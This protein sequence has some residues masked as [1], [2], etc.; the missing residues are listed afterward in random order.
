MKN[1]LSYLALLAPLLNLALAGSVV[2]Y[3][4]SMGENT[5]Q[6]LLALRVHYSYDE[7]ECPSS[8][9]RSWDAFSGAIPSIWAYKEFCGGKD[10]DGTKYSE[11]FCGNMDFFGD[12]GMHVKLQGHDIALGNAGKSTDL[13]AGTEYAKDLCEE[14]RLS[15]S[16]S[17]VSVHEWW[18][19]GKTT[20]V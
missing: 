2:M 3:K 10:G 17:S 7:N 12:A 6:Q 20:C 1:I 8:K 11:E 18:G 15:G 5:N 14:L 4:C 13:D 19:V 9:M 16:Y